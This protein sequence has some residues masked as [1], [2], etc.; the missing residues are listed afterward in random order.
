MPIAY[1]ITAAL[2]FQKIVALVDPASSWGGGAG[3]GLGR[4][5]VIFMAVNL[6]VVQVRSFHSLS[7][8]SMIGAL[9]SVFYALV[10][11]IGSL[12]HGRG[13]GAGAEAVSYEFGAASASKTSEALAFNA[14]NAIATVAFAYGGKRRENGTLLWNG[15]GVCWGGGG[16]GDE[17][18]KDRTAHFRKNKSNQPKQ[19]T[20]SPRRSRPPSPSR[21]PPPGP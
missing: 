9:A 15:S 8:V 6:C 18:E 3:G 14:A 11:F 5:I 4:W 7:S 19:D 16:A 10:A 20:T 13:G 2:S 21:P 17:G 12:V 1:T